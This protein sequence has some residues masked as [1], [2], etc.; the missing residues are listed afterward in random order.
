MH[1]TLRANVVWTKADSLC[2]N[3]LFLYCK[4]IRPLDCVDFRLC[5]SSWWNVATIQIWGRSELGKASVCSVEAK[6]W[7]DDFPVILPSD[8][9]DFWICFSCMYCVISLQVW[10]RSKSKKA[11]IQWICK[12]D[13]F[14]FPKVHNHC[15]G[16]PR[17]FLSINRSYFLLRS[18][19]SV[20]SMRA[21]MNACAWNNVY[22]CLF[23]EKLDSCEGCKIRCLQ[24]LGFLRSK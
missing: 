23:F 12:N 22:A 15:S 8:R 19:S 11:S 7:S 4:K 6:C 14:Q 21:F 18:K 1:T 9:A 17:S 3:L 10:R 13:G 5:C 16:Y 20:H 24:T 2:L